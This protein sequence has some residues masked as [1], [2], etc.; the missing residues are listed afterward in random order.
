ML[1]EA[2]SK[3]KIPLSLQCAAKEQSESVHFDMEQVMN[4]DL[5]NMCTCKG[6][7]AGNLIVLLLK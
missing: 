1:K 7:T 2:H 6:K 5:Y 4:Q 3:N